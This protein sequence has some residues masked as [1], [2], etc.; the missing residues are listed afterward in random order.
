MDNAWALQGL[1]QSLRGQGRKADALGVK[2][3]FVKASA[4]AD[5]DIPGAVY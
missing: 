3:R 2:D 4:K 5:V 1:F